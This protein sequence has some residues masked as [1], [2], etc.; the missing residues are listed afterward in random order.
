MNPEKNTEAIFDAKSL[1]KGKMFV[2]G[3]QHLFAMR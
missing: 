1:G 3:L 2:L